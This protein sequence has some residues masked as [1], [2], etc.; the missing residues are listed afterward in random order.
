[1]VRSGKKKKKIIPDVIGAI[2][3]LTTG[4]RYNLGSI[5]KNGTSEF[6]HS[7]LISAGKGSPLVEYSEIILTLRGMFGNDHP[8]YLRLGHYSAGQAKCASQGFIQ[9]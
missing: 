7:F 8:T 5:G 9:F 4:W 6:S 2:F 1:M 3:F